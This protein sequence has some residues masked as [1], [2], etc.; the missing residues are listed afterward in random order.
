M[1]I[2]KLCIYMRLIF[3]I[4]VLKLSLSLSSQVVNVE[5]KRNKA[6]TIKY[7]G[8]IDFSL[9]ATKTTENILAT[10]NTMQLQKYE[11]KSTYILLS[12]INFMSVDTQKYLNNGFFHLRYNY[13]L[14]QDWLIAE[15]FTQIQFNK[16]QKIL[17]R[18]LWG[19]GFRYNVLDIDNYK[20]SA[21]N[22]M[23][24]EFEF[25]LDNSY[26]DFIRLSNYIAAEININDKFKFKHTTYFQPKIDNFNIYRLHSE[27]AIVSSITDKLKLS[28]VFNLSYDTA[29]PVDVQNTFYTF[30]N[31]LSYVF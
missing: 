19:G 11:D 3:L 2:I 15:G 1:I 26:N 20:L 21:G 17:R 4:V 7:S 29:P 10:R 25:Y 23:M 8:K 9:S 30:T 24:Y 28:I 14:Y 6:D 22:A 18:F 16:V 31:G 13:L 5:H 27:S 12:D